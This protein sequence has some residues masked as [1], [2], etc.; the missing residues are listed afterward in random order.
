MVKMGEGSTII[1]S[2]TQRMDPGTTSP[3]FELGISVDSLTK[4][5]KIEM[6]APCTSLP[7]TSS[8]FVN[9]LALQLSQCAFFVGFFLCL[10]FILSCQAGCDLSWESWNYSK[11]NDLMIQNRKINQ[12]LPSFPETQA[13][14]A[15]YHSQTVYILR[16]LLN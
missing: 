1:S 7:L 13:K 9:P 10:F 12:P 16:K 14:D 5:V 6:C 3:F 8:L 2:E 15:I 11:I 4:W